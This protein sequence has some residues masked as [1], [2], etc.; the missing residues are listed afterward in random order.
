MD[1]GG[2][3]HTFQ[4]SADIFN[5]TNLVNKDWGKRR[6]VRSEIS[7]LTTVGTGST[8]TFQV[9]YGT[10]NDDGTPNMI[11]LD[12]FGLASSRW[13]AQIGLRYIFN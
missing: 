2:K 11:E 7:P 8:P 13:Q 9:N 4:I 6:F 10:V 3:K 12:D 1:F 5:F